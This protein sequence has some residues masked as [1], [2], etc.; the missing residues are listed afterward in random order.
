MYINVFGMPLEEYKFLYIIVT[1]FVAFVLAGS[2]SRLAADAT[3]K[4]VEV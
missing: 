3:P 4:Y 1:V 2:Y